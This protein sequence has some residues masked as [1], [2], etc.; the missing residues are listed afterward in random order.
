[1]TI[2][3]DLAA[4]GVASFVACFILHVLVTF[5]QASAEEEEAQ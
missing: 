3:M 1:M 5:Y 2:L 4:A